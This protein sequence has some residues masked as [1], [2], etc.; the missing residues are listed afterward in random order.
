MNKSV[1]RLLI[2]GI[3]TIICGISLFIY[4]LTSFAEI[5]GLENKINFDE[6]DNNNQMPTAEKY[7]KHLSIADLLNQKLNENKNLI[8]KNTACAYLDYA[9]HNT[10][11]L[12]KLIYNGDRSDISRREIVELNVRNLYNLLGNYANC[13]NAAEYKQG[14]GQILNDIQKSNDLYQSSGTALDSFLRTSGNIQRQENSQAKEPQGEILLQDSYSGEDE[15]Y[16]E[17]IVPRDN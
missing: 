17:Q 4:S 8:I 5:K 14:L 3:V 9:H 7:Y 12:Y 1:N 16:L 10:V 15:E 6:L 13:K 11:S 2:L